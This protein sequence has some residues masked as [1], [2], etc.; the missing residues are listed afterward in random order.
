[1]PFLSAV[2]LLTIGLAGFLGFGSRTPTVPDQDVRFISTSGNAAEVYDFPDTTLTLA[3]DLG[4]VQF[5]LSELI[6]ISGT[7]TFLNVE[8]VARDSHQGTLTS[9]IIQ[10]REAGT[11]RRFMTEGDVINL[12]ATHGTLTQDRLPPHVEI[13]FI[14]GRRIHAQ[15][16]GVRIPLMIDNTRIE[17]PVSDI[18]ALRII[19]AH[20]E[21]PTTVIISFL[22]GRVQRGLLE[23][24]G[25][26]IRV[27]DLFLNELEFPLSS[28]RSILAEKSILS[29]LPISFSSDGS[30]MVQFKNGNDLHGKIPRT[31]WRIDTGAGTITLS[32][33]VLLNIE[34]EKSGSSHVQTVMGERFTGRITPT[35]FTLNMH[36]GPVTVDL[37]SV[38]SIAFSSSEIALPDQWMIATFANNDQAYVRFPNVRAPVGNAP[39]AMMDRIRSIVPDGRRR[40]ILRTDRDASQARTDGPRT[41]L[42]VA[43]AT[44]HLHTRWTDIKSLVA[45]TAVDDPSTSSEPAPDSLTAVSELMRHKEEESL[46]EQPDAGNQPGPQVQPEKHPAPEA[47]RGQESPPYPEPEIQPEPPPPQPESQQ[48]VRLRFDSILGQL[49]L[50]ATAIAAVHLADR[51]R[52]CFIE[53]VSGDGLAV[54]RIRQAQLRDFAEALSLGPLPDSGTLALRASRYDRTAATEQIPVWR[55]ADGSVFA[56]RIESPH[57]RFRPHGGSRGQTVEIATAGIETLARIDRN[58]VMMTTRQGELDGRILTDRIVLTP[59]VTG[60][61]FAIRIS[62]I[63]SMSH[64]GFSRLPPALDEH[65]S[66]PPH[67][68]NQVLIE[69]GAF[70]QGN[71]APD[72]LPDETPPYPAV[73]SDFWI[74]RAPVTV[75]QFAR[76]C[77]ATGY[78]TIAEKQRRSITWRQPGFQQTALDPVVA[79]S[80]IDA[81]AFCNWRSLRAGLAPVYTLTALPDVE[82]DLW[83]DGFRLPSEAE[84]EFAA[85]ERGQDLLYPWGN[86]V[87]PD[88]APANFSQTAGAPQDGWLYTN[89]VM[90]FP[91]NSL[92]LYDMAGNTWEWCQ[93]WFHENAYHVLR[94]R[95]SRNP[96]MITPSQ[97]SPRRSMRGG[98]FNSGLDFMRTTS[99]GH[100][101]PFASSHHVGFRCVRSTTPVAPADP[102]P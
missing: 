65:S 84:W 32:S 15:R 39:A 34:P 12:T 91:P 33:E 8:T 71:A 64:A 60:A 72:A 13:H 1:M 73:V 7:S 58:R 89:P 90:A 36:E 87:P 28:I 97:P 27:R 99:R 63:E 46:R 75:A 35:R 47:S 22:S 68:G 6:S 5:S 93:D 53:T 80:W 18:R 56:A 74:D 23:S 76:F 10:Y 61:E 51:G 14:N 29:A 48:P 100:G 94:Q 37:E 92:G 41:E 40:V 78:T 9:G 44:D 38:S 31:L 86:T 57:L 25:R 101:H 11:I 62:E 42:V 4:A 66:R 81:A 43:S 79:V 59:T 70:M 54:Y 20:L 77:E 16:D 19:A 85:R 50:P 69:G 3:T 102:Q 82:I 96:L 95:Q 49:N 52:S 24:P 17:I 45:R 83:A 26:T 30:V 98:A 21:D 2:Q 55:L 88:R 67:F